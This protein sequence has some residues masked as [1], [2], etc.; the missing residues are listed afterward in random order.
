[1]TVVGQDT[2]D[3]GL[4]NV[5]SEGVGSDVPPNGVQEGVVATGSTFTY[6]PGQYALDGGSQDLMFGLSGVAPQI[7]DVA[8][9]I[10]NDGPLT[11]P[12]QAGRYDILFDGTPSCPSAFPALPAPIVFESVDAIGNTVL[13]PADGSGATITNVVLSGSGATQA[14]NNVLEFESGSAS[15]IQVTVSFNYSISNAGCP[16]CIDQIAVGLNSDPGPQVCPYFGIDGP[17]PGVTGTSGNFTINV[18]NTPG[19]YYIGYNRTEEYSCVSSWPSG[20][21]P[22]SAYLGVVD[23]WPTP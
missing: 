7:C 15:T 6:L 3:N 21:P 14:A 8:T 12:T 16:D 1:M 19:R 18:P 9:N 2:Q 10:Y 20:P 5:N 23:V 17:S 13:S 22:P 11:A 4:V